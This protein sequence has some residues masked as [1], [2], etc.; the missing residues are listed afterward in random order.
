MLEGVVGCGWLNCLVSLQGSAQ[1]SITVCSQSMH[2]AAGMHYLKHLYSTGIYPN[3]ARTRMIPAKK[4]M[5][6]RTTLGNKKT[7]AVMA[8]PKHKQQNIGK[9]Q[10]ENMA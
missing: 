2:M 10:I 8:S 5:A 7:H 9:E 1:S 3:H 4:E 6:R